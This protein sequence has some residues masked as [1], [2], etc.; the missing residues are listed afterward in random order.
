MVQREHQAVL[1][2]PALLPQEVDPDRQVA[3]LGEF[4]VGEDAFLFGFQSTDAAGEAGR[5]K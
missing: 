2:L 1:A 4:A 5:G 3:V